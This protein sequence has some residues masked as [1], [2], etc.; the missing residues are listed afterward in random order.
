MPSASG[1]RSQRVDQDRC[2]LARARLAGGD[3]VDVQPLLPADD[4]VARNVLEAAFARSAD[5]SRI[6]D[7]VEGSRSLWRKDRG[8]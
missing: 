6:A 1:A 4:D 7:A 8:R 3:A 2:R 5:S